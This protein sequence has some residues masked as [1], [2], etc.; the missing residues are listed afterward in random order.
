MNK[1]VDL[2][3]ETLK[4]KSLYRILFNWQVARHC[5]NL[6]GVC[7]DLACGKKPASYWRYWKI[8]LSRLVRI[9]ASKEAKPDIEADLNQGIPLD[10]D[11]ADNIFM[12][13]SFY[14]IKDPQTLAREIARVLKPGGRAFITAQFIKSEEN[15]ADDRFRFTSRQLKE[16]FGCAG[17]AGAQIFPTGE[18]FSA[19][20]NLADFVIGNSLAANCLKII[21]RPM[22]LLADKIL[23]K[24]VKQNYPCPLAWF[25]IAKKVF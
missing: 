23:P 3:K 11:F 13:N 1:A 5:V 19:I 10:N 15:R 24:K 20:G 7:V 17:F 9:D 22:C 6:E 8:N 18:R 21:F 25:V 12:F 2:I 14:L 4:G 16:I